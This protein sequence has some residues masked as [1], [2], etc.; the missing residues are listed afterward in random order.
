MK[1]G[2]IILAGGESR[3]MGQDKAALPWRDTDL[4]T[5]LL[6]RSQKVP[7]A[8][9]LLVINRPYL[10]AA[11]LSLSFSSTLQIFGD[12]YPH[13]G[14]LGG[15][16][17][18]FAR[19]TCE[20]YLVL[21]VDLPFYDF[22]PLAWL[23]PQLTA[24]MEAVIPVTDGK[25][26]P[27]AAL[28]RASVYPLLR[29]NLAQQDLRLRHFY[30]KLAALYPDES[31][32]AIFYTNLNEPA[33][34]DLALGREENRKRRVPLV[35]ISA[36]AANGGKTTACI[37]LLIA[38]RKRG[39]RVGYVKSTHHTLILPKAGADTER[40][41]KAGAVKSL[42]CTPQSLQMGENKT[43]ALLRLSQRM[44][45]D[46]VLIESRAHGPAPVLDITTYPDFSLLL[47]KVLFLTGFIS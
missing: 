8:Q 16:E 1:L 34:Y 11:D 33:D 13:Q 22:S 19:G 25:E 21:A 44:D 35:T 41:Q 12:N 31:T 42:I 29:K 37:H 27:L 30:Q 18:A 14:P 3:R 17:A 43:Q 39:L 2:L 10:P 47:E 9:R 5:D 23:L 26:Q 40:A 4:L 24:E 45:A 38:L 28:Y 46:L 15:L 32:R 6:K 7:F 36:P 20:S